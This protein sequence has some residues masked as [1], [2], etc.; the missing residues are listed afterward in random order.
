[1]SKRGL[2]SD[3]MSCTVMYQPYA[4]SSSN[5]GVCDRPPAE[6]KPFRFP[7]VP[8]PP[9]SLHSDTSSYSPGPS[10]ST[11]AAAGPPP[12]P[13]HSPQLSLS[14]SLNNSSS[15]STTGNGRRPLTPL[16][17]LVGPTFSSPS[18]SAPATI[19]SA[20]QLLQI[21]QQQQ[22]QHHSLGGRSPHN[23]MH[24]QHHSHSHSSSSTATSNSSSSSASATITSHTHP[25]PAHLLDHPNT[26]G[27]EPSQQ[28]QQQSNNDNNDQQQQVGN[29]GGGG[30]NRVQYLSANCIVYENYREETARVVED[31]F[32]RAL[33]AATSTKCS[34]MS[35]RN[36]PPSFWNSNYQPQPSSSK[37]PFVNMGGY[38]ASDF[39]GAAVDYAGSTLS[40]LGHHHHHQADPWH[41]PLTSHHQGYHRATDLSPYPPMPST[42][43]FNAA[44]Y[45]SFFLAGAAATSSAASRFATGAGQCGAN[46]KGD[47]TSW[48]SGLYHHPHEAISELN[49][50]DYAA[51]AHYTNRTA[52]G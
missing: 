19:T 13:T 51:A 46:L 14:L 22:Q 34:P 6:K 11:A 41:Y 16:L 25:H 42:S 40:G 31:H 1:M 10:S 4:M 50:A 37:Q 24:R 28:Q 32:N 38:S 45:G 33:S 30:G 52:A 43:R 15:S 48:S 39:Y 21:Q 29:G 8:S 26:D 44:Q 9:D 20:T 18:S 7:Y 36:F 49:L 27:G 17:G 23:S 3:K 5:Y 2:E 12:N 35:T 47:S